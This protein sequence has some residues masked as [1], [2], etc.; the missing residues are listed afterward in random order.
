MRISISVSVLAILAAIVHQSDG[1]ARFVCPP[2]QSANSGREEPT[3]RP[4]SRQRYT[5]MTPGPQTIQIEETVFHE[6]SAMRIE[7]IKDAGKPCLLL[8]HIP[9]N[10]SSD[11]TDCSVDTYPIGRCQKS[12][13][14]VTVNIPN[15]DCDNCQLRLTY[16][17]MD[18][19]T[20]TGIC[21]TKPSNCTTYYSCSDVKIR[22]TDPS[23]DNVCPQD[24][25]SWPYHSKFSFSSTLSPF[26]K[27]SDADDSGPTPTPGYFTTMPPTLASGSA[28]LTLEGK[29][30]AYTIQYQGLQGNFTMAHI[31]G[32]A[33]PGEDADVVEDL[34]PNFKPVGDTGS[35]VGQ[36]ANLDETKMQN[37]KNGLYYINIHSSLYPDGEIRGQIYLT[38]SEYAPD[39]YIIE[40]GQYN[41][42]GWLS[43]DEFLSPT[44]KSSRFLVGFGSCAKER[45]RYFGTGLSSP[46]LES[47]M[48]TA[49]IQTTS[50]RAWFGMD[51]AGIPGELQSVIID[52]SAAFAAE[53]KELIDFKKTPGHVMGVFE[54]T[55]NQ[56]TAL[57]KG[58]LR[59]TV[60]FTDS[61]VQLQGTFEEAMIAM[62]ANEFETPPSPKAPNS[63]GTASLVFTRNGYL[64]VNITI[65]G[66]NSE[67]T[68][69]HIHGPG[70]QMQTGPLLFDLSSHIMKIGDSDAHVSASVHFDSQSSMSM[71]YLWENRLYINIH[72]VLAP[73]GELRNQISKPGKWHC[74]GSA[75]NINQ[76]FASNLTVNQ[77]QATHPV[78][79]SGG[80][81]PTPSGVAGTYIDR[82]GD[83]HYS[84]ALSD[85]SKASITGAH[86]HGPAPYGATGGAL[87]VINHDDFTPKAGERD[88]VIELNGVWYDLT[89]VQ[90]SFAKNGELYFNIHTEDNPDGVLRAQLP[91]L[92]RSRCGLPNKD[93]TVKSSDDTVGFIAGHPYANLRLLQNDI[94]HISFAPD[95]KLYLLENKNRFDGCAYLNSQEVVG[96]TP[97]PALPGGPTPPLDGP[98][99][100]LNDGPNLPKPPAMTS[101]MYKLTE[102]GTLYFAGPEDH[103]NQ[104]PPMKFSVTVKPQLS[105]A[106]RLD[107]SVCQQSD[108]AS[109][110]VESTKTGSTGA[111]TV[112]AVF[113]GISV[114]VV[115][116]VIVLVLNHRRSKSGGM[117]VKA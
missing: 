75:I 9:H 92:E 66:V 115:I 15:V 117:D 22:G 49:A 86:I 78:K 52:S 7:L 47:T 40:S 44:S 71:R 60:S 13:Y 14:Y 51:I 67:V 105:D 57:T 103:C 99:P 5:D 76:C 42:D 53:T 82:L 56:W 80:G 2:P 27:D 59:I 11:P 88:H 6:G 17:N 102:P 65:T 104:N 62:L 29:N 68:K 54:L 81:I 19:A 21:S 69:A 43:G 58:G 33:N 79:I 12:T 96:T 39:R 72:T 74:E 114:G 83:L 106:D 41:D 18:K 110:V 112:A 45:T 101:I 100:P 30:V 23:L 35:A 1:H 46:S 61:S 50:N 63:V 16:V 64:N 91:K 85:I 36:W 26:M 116:V 94:L 90:K 10:P 55:Q 93:V 111:K 97:T 31:H 8:D 109:S 89:D 84:L 20:K 108:F 113:I 87:H 95:H 32:P 24:L 98:T 25:L 3:C 28:T 107:D 70:R 38:K 4:F 37:L 48:G 34:T 73:T 77:S